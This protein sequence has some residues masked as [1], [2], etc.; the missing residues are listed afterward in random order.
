MFTAL[1][2]KVIRHRDLTEQEAAAAMTEVMEGRVAP[3]ALAGLL[4]VLAMKGERPQRN[5]RLRSHDAGAR[6]S[7]GGAARPGFRHVRH[8]R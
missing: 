7:P 3:G 8:G 6:R 4:A 1:I 2:E 5:R